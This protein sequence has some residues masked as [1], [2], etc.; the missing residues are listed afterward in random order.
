M[1]SMLC[2][3]LISIPICIIDDFLCDPSTNKLIKEKILFTVNFN[4]VVV[5]ANQ[6]IF[7]DDSNDI[8]SNLLKKLL[9][10]NHSDQLASINYQSK[11]VGDNSKKKRGKS[12]PRTDTKIDQLTLHLIQNKALKE[13]RR[14]DSLSSTRIRHRLTSWLIRV[15]VIEIKYVQAQHEDLYLTVQIGNRTFWTSTKPKGEV[16]FNEVQQTHSHL[17]DFQF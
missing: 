11:S 6:V 1:Y 12:K 5:L 9:E 16:Q 10:I 8:S 17:F 3:S 14:L 15:N 4:P 7:A 2:E 13:I